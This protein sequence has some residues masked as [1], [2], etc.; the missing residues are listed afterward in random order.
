M[1]TYPALTA[2]T[3]PGWALL[4]SSASAL[5]FAYTGWGASSDPRAI[6]SH[7]WHSATATL[8]VTALY[9]GLTFLS[10]LAKAS[11]GTTSS[12]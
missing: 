4:R 8:R 11:P 10:G 9:F 12:R 5:L 6:A 1:M 7:L 2:R 3:A